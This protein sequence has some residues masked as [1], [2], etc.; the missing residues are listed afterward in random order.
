[1][2]AATKAIPHSLVAQAY[3]SHVLSL[4]T[5]VTT[6]RTTVLGPG[7]PARY[8]IDRR[9]NYCSV[10]ASLTV[11]ALMPKN[12]KHLTNQTQTMLPR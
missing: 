5:T 6:T 8:S 1:M 3:G 2:L 7:S 10:K 11:D 12:G 4:E 9:L